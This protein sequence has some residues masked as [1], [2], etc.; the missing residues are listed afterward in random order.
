MLDT[1]VLASGFI[2]TWSPPGQLLIGWAAGAF[3]LIVSDPILAELASTLQHRYFLPRLPASGAAGVIDLLKREAV[4]T[5]ITV[6]VHGVAT[7][8]EDDLV[9]ATALSGAAGY[10][11]TGD[12]QLLRLG[13][14]QGVS[15]LSPRT[16]LDLLSR[17]PS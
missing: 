13:S 4:L 2:R 9:L 11:V 5:P 1:N 10:L 12:G 16:F 7:H 6:E 8:P 17:S 3:D 14:F 15:I